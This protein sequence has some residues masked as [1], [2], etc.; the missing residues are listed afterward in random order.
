MIKCK[1]K[2]FREAFREVG[3]NQSGWLNKND[4]VKQHFQTC[5]LAIL[6]NSFFQLN[7]LIEN[8][9]MAVAVYNIIQQVTY[10]QFPKTKRIGQ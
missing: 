1:S 9:Q 3:R 6:Y 4:M 5:H 8:I 10:H 2:I 7:I